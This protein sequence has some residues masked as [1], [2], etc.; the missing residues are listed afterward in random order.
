MQDKHSLNYKASTTFVV[1]WGVYNIIKTSCLRSFYINI[2]WQM[3]IINK[4]EEKMEG[5]FKI[6]FIDYYF[7]D[8]QKEINQFKK[9][10]NIEIIDC[11]NILPGLIASEDQLLPHLKKLNALDTDAVLVNHAI[12]TSKFIRQ[13]TNCKI[14]LRYGIG[15][16]NIDIKAAQAMGIRVANVP[17]YCIEEVSE[18]AVALI[19]VCTRKMFNQYKLLEKH[20]FNYEAIKPIHRLSHLTLGLLAFGKIAQRVAEKIKNFNI[21]IIAYDPHFTKR[22][23][24]DFIQFVELDELLMKADIISIHVPLNPETYHFINEKMINKMKKGVMI[25]NTARGGLVEE[26]ALYEGLISG[27]IACAGL[28]VLEIADENTYYRSKLMLL[29]N[30]IVTPH[31]SWYSEEATYDLQ[32]KAGQIVYNELLKYLDN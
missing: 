17:D 27:K 14:I 10:G 3:I 29:D 28:D 11:N 9:L 22:K 20:Q 15:V 26:D 24:Y 13:L 32:V 21:K 31:T 23:N 12:I 4:K 5:K 16:D 19:L 2:F 1:A 6:V 25:I 18:N 7:P 8:I 30:V